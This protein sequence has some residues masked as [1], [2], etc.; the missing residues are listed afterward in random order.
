MMTTASC[1]RC[2]GVLACCLATLLAGVLVTAGCTRGQ[3]PKSDTPG[4]KAAPDSKDR[5]R[6]K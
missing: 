4:K 1:Y 3:E 2:R 5:S 6:S